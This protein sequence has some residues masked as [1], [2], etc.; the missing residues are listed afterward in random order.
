MLSEDLIL[1]TIVVLVLLNDGHV[2]GKF[3]MISQVSKSCIMWV[4]DV[5]S[6]IWFRESRVLVNVGSSKDYF[7]DVLPVLIITIR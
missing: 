6:S 3:R 7:K 4:N 5:S 2:D 1:T